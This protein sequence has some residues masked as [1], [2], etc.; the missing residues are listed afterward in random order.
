MIAHLGAARI[1]QDRAVAERA[2]THLEA[3]LEPADDLAVGQVLRHPAQQL[4]LRNAPV[5]Q[6]GLRP[7]P[8]GSGR[9]CRPGR[10]TACVSSK[11]RGMAQRLV[12]VPQRA[13]E[14]RAGVGGARRHP[15]APHVGL[16]EDLGVG[17]AVE[18]DAADHAQVAHAGTSCSS[19]RTTPQHDLLGHGLQGEGEVAVPVG[20]RLVGRAGGAER[21]DEL[22]LEGPQLAEGVVAEIV[23]V[24]GIAAVGRRA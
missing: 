4:R 11:P 14:R 9:R 7:A 13:A 10:R 3:A 19:A 12:V 24:D 2:R 16:L 8:A 17:H 6:A 15:D 21:V 22:A 23:H 20:E 1:G 5:V 18:R